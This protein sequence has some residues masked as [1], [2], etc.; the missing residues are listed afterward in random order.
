MK[1]NAQHSTNFM[2]WIVSSEISS[3]RLKCENNESAIKK[4]KIALDGW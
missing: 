2:N 4:F 3:Q 1:K